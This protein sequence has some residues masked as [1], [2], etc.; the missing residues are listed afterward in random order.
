MNIDTFS[1]CF[2]RGYDCA[3]IG[4]TQLFLWPRYSYIIS[5]LTVTVRGYQISIAYYL[6]SFF[7]LKCTVR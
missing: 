3:M 7:L 1:A 2:N 4:H 6:V 5:L